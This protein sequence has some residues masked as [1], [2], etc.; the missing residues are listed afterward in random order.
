M[1]TEEKQYLTKE[2]YKELEEEL[3]YLKDTRRK[4]VAENLQ[5]AKSLGDLSENA[6]YQEARQTQAE[7]EERISQLESLLQHAEIAPSQKGD[8]VGIGST[9]TIKKKNAKENQTYTIV[10]AEEADMASGKISYKSPIGEALLGQEKGATVTCKTPAG[11][12]E[13]TIVDVK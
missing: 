10:G 5:Y 7:I 2:K 3:A 6:E 1:T 13:C 9:V 12:M 4:E 11:D 8:I